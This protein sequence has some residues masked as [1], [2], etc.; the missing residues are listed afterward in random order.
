M[1]LNEVLPLCTQS[2]RRSA[3]HSKHGHVIFDFAL[4]KIPSIKRT[5][6]S[7]LPN[8]KSN[9]IELDK[10]SSAGIC[11]EPTYGLLRRICVMRVDIDVL[12]RL[13]KS[14]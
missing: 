4:C 2:R 11:G 12:N 14:R 6:C 8:S 13:Y 10:T 1:G 5:A 9:R 3:A 7:S